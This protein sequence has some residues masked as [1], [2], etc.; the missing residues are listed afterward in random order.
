MV[1]CLAAREKLERHTVCVNV[2]GLQLEIDLR[3]IMII[4]AAIGEESGSIVGKTN[5]GLF[6]LISDS[7]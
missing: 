7:C 3:A 5:T 4:R 6:L 2:S 1:R